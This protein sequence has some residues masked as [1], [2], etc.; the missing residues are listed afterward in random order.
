MQ[1]QLAQQDCACVLEPARHLRVL[2]GYAI[3][4]QLT[5]ASGANAGGVDVVLQR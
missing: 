4:K 1:V 3:F 2:G 5:G